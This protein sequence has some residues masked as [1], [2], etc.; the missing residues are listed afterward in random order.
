MRDQHAFMDILR[1]REG[2]GVGADAAAKIGKRQPRC[3][4]GRR[5]QRKPFQPDALG[6]DVL[7][8]ADLAMEL[9]RARLDGERARG[10][11]RT[12]GLVEDADRDAEPG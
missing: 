8:N 11:T 3:D 6:K 1:Q 5:M 2:E 4:A 10:F 7:D 9:Q 12:G